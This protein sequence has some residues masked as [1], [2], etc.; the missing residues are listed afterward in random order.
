MRRNTLFSPVPSV[1]HCWRRRGLGAIRLRPTGYRPRRS[2]PALFRRWWERQPVSVTCVGD[3]VWTAGRTPSTTTIPGLR[4]TA[5]S[6][7]DARPGNDDRAA[8][9]L[10]AYEGPD[11][12]ISTDGVE[13]DYRVDRRRDLS[14]RPPGGGAGPGARPSCIERGGGGGGGGGQPPCQEP[15]GEYL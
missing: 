10:P 3:R 1:A 2:V 7:C 13:R 5:P 9:S 11:A 4:R 6:N 14:R 12:R 8:G 15:R